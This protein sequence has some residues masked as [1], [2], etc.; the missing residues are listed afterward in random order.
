MSPNCSKLRVTGSMS[1]ILRYKIDISIYQDDEIGDT[2]AITEGSWIDNE[3]IELHKDFKSP[4]KKIILSKVKD[5]LNRFINGDIRIR[6]TSATLSK[7]ERT[8][9]DKST[10]DS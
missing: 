2:W 1:A 9:P 5:E 10:W 3:L 7:N 4:F 8:S 6:E